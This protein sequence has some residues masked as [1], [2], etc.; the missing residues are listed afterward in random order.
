MVPSLLETLFFSFLGL[1]KKCETVCKEQNLIFCH[2]SNAA[3]TG[4]Y[5]E[6]LVVMANHYG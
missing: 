3:I 6:C 1:I 2:R 4:F 5:V